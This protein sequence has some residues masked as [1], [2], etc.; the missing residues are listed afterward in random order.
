MSPR[1]GLLSLL[2][3]D[4]TSRRALEET[5]ADW[6]EER[7]RAESVLPYVL[8]HVR[9]CFAVVRVVA[10][11]TTRGFLLTETWRVVVGSIAVAAAGSLIFIPGIWIGMKWDPAAASVMWASWFLVPQVMLPLLA[12]AAAIGFGMR[13]QRGG[14][15]PAT[16]LLTALTMGLVGWGVPASNQAYR[17]VVAQQAR[18]TRFDLAIRLNRGE[19]VLN[20]GE[21]VPVE[22]P[23]ELTIGELIRH[24]RPSRSWNVDAILGQLSMRGALVLAVP[25]FFLLGITVR[26]TLLRR[27]SWRIAQAASG[28]IGIALFFTATGAIS[29]IRPLVGNPRELS[30]AGISVWIATLFAMFTIALLARFAANPEPEPGT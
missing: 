3:P 1:T 4:E 8:V 20:R 5:L 24:Q 27:W 9:G 18:A 29:F 7:A 28:A 17:T 14:T 21:F 26:G 11:I 19:I 25:T 10:G 30:H 13:T 22:G 2:L 6:R 15:L 12:P 23:A 16:V